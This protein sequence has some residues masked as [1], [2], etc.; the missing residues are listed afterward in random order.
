MG[1]MKEP[2]AG[3]YEAD[4][5]AW[6]QQ[7]AALLKRGDFALLDL[8]NLVEEIESLGRS[9]E[10]ELESRLAQLMMHLLKWQFQ[11]MQRSKSWTHTIEEQRYRLGLLFKRMP[12]LQPRAGEFAVEA[13]SDARLMAER[14][15]GLMISTFPKSSP[16]A[17]EQVLDPAWLPPGDTP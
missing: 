13:Y 1:A 4:Y 12:S 7:Q 5:H 2:T 11:P 10:R 17:I 3:L 16:Y 9:E 8:P 14:E 15:T 6:T